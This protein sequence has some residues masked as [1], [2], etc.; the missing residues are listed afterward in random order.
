MKN[1][2]LKILVA[3]IV[4]FGFYYIINNS[5]IS[6][7]HVKGDLNQIDSEDIYED[8]SVML[9]SGKD[10]ELHVEKCDGQSL[11]NVELITLCFGSGRQSMGENIYS[12]I[13]S[14]KDIRYGLYINNAKSG[15]N[16][17]VV[18]VNTDP[19]DPNGK[20]SIRLSDKDLEF[21]NF[22]ILNFE[23]F[24]IVR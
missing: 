22:V 12:L 23:N 13:S 11:K 14:E 4:I 20:N 10:I 18:S 6:S 8:I 19:K 5:S 9:P 3:I 16:A 1:N 17:Y 15:E 21:V 24:Q 2:I 7:N